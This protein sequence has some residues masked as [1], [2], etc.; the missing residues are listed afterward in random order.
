MSR[1]RCNPSL[2]RSGTSAS[3]SRP[4][5]WRRVN[6]VGAIANY[7][8]IRATERIWSARDRR[9][10]RGCVPGAAVSAAAPSR[11][12]ACRNA[13]RQYGSAS[14][15][16]RLPSRPC[17]LRQHEQCVRLGSASRVL[18][19]YTRDAFWVSSGATVT[20]SVT[21]LS[22]TVPATDGSRERRAPL[23]RRCRFPGPVRLGRGARCHASRG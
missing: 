1:Y 16:V 13:I 23:L 6:D 5:K 21:T 12:P 4:A 8:N 2:Q 17:G 3:S 7:E 19:D 15:P 14:L 22:G 20:E 9:N 10:R 11:R 18:A